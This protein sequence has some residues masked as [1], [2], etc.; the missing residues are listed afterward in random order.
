MYGNPNYGGWGCPPQQSGVVYVPAPP[1]QGT[2]PDPIAYIT[3]QIASL[4]N[5]KKVLK[6]E[7]KDDKKDDKKKG[8]DTNVVNMM[9]LMILLSPITGP[10]MSHFFSWGLSYLPH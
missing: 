7:K 2:N 6:E 9:F 5:L 4:E 10:M 1:A 8:A 3:S